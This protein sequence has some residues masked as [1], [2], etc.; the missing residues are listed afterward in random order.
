MVNMTSNGSNNP[1]TEEVAFDPIPSEQQ[2]DKVIPEEDVSPASRKDS[3]ANGTSPFKGGGDEYYGGGVPPPEQEKFANGPPPPRAGSAS[4]PDVPSWWQANQAPLPAEVK[5]SSEGAG[6][7]GGAVSDGAAGAS[8]GDAGSAEGLPQLNLDAPSL[9]QEDEQPADGMTTPKG[10]GGGISPFGK[11]PGG[12]SR[13]AASV[14]S[15]AASG[16]GSV[17]GMPL[18]VP[19][20]VISVGEVISMG[21]YDATIEIQPGQN[22]VLKDTE[23]LKAGIR[24]EMILAF[25]TADD[26]TTVGAKLSFEKLLFKVFRIVGI[27][28]VVRA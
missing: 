5:S 26:G 19:Q 6:V 15:P 11:S 12:Q 10:A 2:D 16:A 3:S 24:P 7:P 8:V 27:L 9:E 21:K 18:V 17:G 4:R 23:L 20:G 28:L 22:A 1:F 13:S 14:V 25:Q